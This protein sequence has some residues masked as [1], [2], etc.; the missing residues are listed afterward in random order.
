MQIV[1]NA[2][3]SAGDYP[4]L[5]Q[6]IAKQEIPLNTACEAVRRPRCYFPYVRPAGEALYDLPLPAQGLS[7]RIAQALA[8]RAMFRVSQRKIAEARLDL[9]ACHRLGRL[10]GGGPLLMDG[11]AG[12]AIEDTANHADIALVEFGNLSASDALV[13]RDELRKLTP[14]PDIAD[15]FD[16]G[17]RLLFLGFLCE[18]I[19]DTHAK[20]ALL[21]FI[22]V[23]GDRL[24][25]H[26]AEI[27]DLVLQTANKEWDRWTAA[28]RTSN[29]AQRR[30]NMENLEAEFGGYRALDPFK[31]SW[32][33]L[34]EDGRRLGRATVA[35]MLPNV[36][37]APFTEERHRVHGDL[38]QLA[39]ALRAYR[40]DHHL[41]PADLVDLVPKYCTA[42]PLDHFSGTPLHYLKRQNGYLLYSVG[43]NNS[44]DGGHG[45]NSRPQGD[46]V[47]LEIPSMGYPF[48]T[49]WTGAASSPTRN[50]DLFL[51]ALWFLG[52]L[53]LNGLTMVIARIKGRAR[54]PIWLVLPHGALVMYVLVLLM[55]VVGKNIAGTIGLVSLGLFAVTV[56]AGGIVYLVSLIRRKTISLP[57]VIGHSALLLIALGI[58]LPKIYQ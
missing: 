20:M 28:I 2:P 18:H 3:W 42:L 5:A 7:V 48:V 24:S 41:Y 17:E 44:D 14:L 12:L 11:L 37:T 1:T 36:K 4:E 19:R 34:R 25:T 31:T 9:L 40:A 43:A 10:V 45:W 27:W 49:L 6:W 50:E 8:A 46:D 56:L 57:L 30:K 47:G 53:A 29:S 21:F 16:R 32:K 55:Y 13:Y 58:V 26:L 23:Y 52:L 33:F 22:P 38:T 39:F 54:P 15:R 51:P 35:I